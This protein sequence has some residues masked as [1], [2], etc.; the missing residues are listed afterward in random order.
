[1][2]DLLA[3]GIPVVADAV[4]QNC[5]Y[6]QHNQSGCLVPAEDDAAF[7]Q[8]VITLLQEPET[9]QRLGQVARQS[10]QEKFAWSSLA[11][12]LEKSYH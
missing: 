3:A 4:G 7:S 10:L 9:R 6:I 11:E 8:M 1:L 12:T 5:E 2:I